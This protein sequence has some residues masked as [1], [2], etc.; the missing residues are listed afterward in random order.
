MLKAA[1]KR[2]S[3]QCR[4]ISEI[5]HHQ[6]VR[7]GLKKENS[8]V[9]MVFQQPAREPERQGDQTGLTSHQGQETRRKSRA[10]RV[11]IVAKKSQVYGNR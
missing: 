10:Q 3:K 8:L 2:R 1:G 6:D 7:V 5:A 4:F 11:F 9:I